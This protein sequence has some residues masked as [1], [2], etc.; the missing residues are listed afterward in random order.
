MFKLY[1]GPD[2][3]FSVI[4]LTPSPPQTNIEYDFFRCVAVQH[5]MCMFLISFCQTGQTP[6][7]L[8]WGPCVFV[9]I[10]K[11]FNHDNNIEIDFNFFCCTPN[12]LVSSLCLCVCL[13]FSS[14]IYYVGDWRKRE[15]MW[16]SF[17][18]A[19]EKIINLFGI[20]SGRNHIRWKVI[21]N[22]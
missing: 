18:K 13:P 7:P 8:W 9:W 22:L 10:N 14:L 3:N 15:S 12:P 1:E 21:K 5:K 19:I 2:T 17:R 11:F 16:K 4:S 6:K 20:I